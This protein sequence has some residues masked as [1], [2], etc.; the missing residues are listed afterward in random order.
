MISKNAH[1]G[2]NVTIKEGVIVEDCAVISDGCFLDYNCIIRSHVKLGK[3]SYV[4]P[5]CILGEYN[6][7][8]YKNFIEEKNDLIIGDNAI[9]RS[10]CVVYGG[11]KI[12][13]N[14][15]TGHHVTIRENTVA[16]E[17]LKVGTLSDI[18]GDCVIG[19]YVNLHSNVHLGK[20]SK[21]G[22][23]VWIFPYCVFTNDPI[24]PSEHEWGCTVKDYA[25][26]ASRS[27]LLPGVIIGENSLIGAGS[28]VTENIPSD[29]V[30]VGS[31]A[32]IKCEISQLKDPI[33]LEPAY[34]WPFHFQRNMPWKSIGFEEWEKAL[35]FQKD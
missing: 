28:V 18:Q 11:S 6:Y 5:N 15:Q 26:I 31:P 3:G 32:K 1:I 19:E 17:Q 24:P 30:A 34:P 29:V 16:G 7:D 14:F 35:R 13:N 27:V 8:F 22:N 10:H 33:T 20:A 25:V 9:I 2:K 12:G 21:I 23:F 4:G